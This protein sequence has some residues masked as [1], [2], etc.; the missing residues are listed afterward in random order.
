MSHY[1]KII[2]GTICLL[3]VNFAMA[4]E[5][6]LSLFP[7][8]HY[9]QNVS[10]WIKS[11]DADYDQLLLSDEMQQQRLAIFNEHLFGNDSPWSSEYVTRVMENS[12][13]RDIEYME[14]SLL[15]YFNNK[16]KSE[17]EIGY[18]EN[19]RPYSQKWIHDIAA[20][21]NA[22]QFKHVKYIAD[23]RA[24]AVQNLE[25]RALPTED[26]F[27]NTYQKAGQGYPFDLLQMSAIWAGTPLYILGETQDHAWYLV[28]TPSYI[29]WVKSAGVARA[30]SSFV[31][32][33][34]AAAT[35]MLA[36]ITH[37]KTSISNANG[38][39][40]FYGYVGSVFPVI[41]GADTL[42]LMV[43][44][45]DD[46]NHATIAFA[47][48]SS[49]QAAMMPLAATPHH[50]ADLMK[51]LIGRPYGW[52]GSYFLNDCSQE[53]RSL[54]TP[55]GIWLPRHSSTQVH[56]GKM[57]DMS[58]A[59]KDE[60]INYLMKHGK[61]FLTLIYI[62]GH[63]VLYVGNYQ[64]P[65]QPG[66]MM[67]MTYQDVWGLSPRSHATRH[68]IGGSVLIPMLPQYPEDK[69]LMSLADKKYF[70]MGFLDELPQTHASRH[71]PA[72]VLLRWK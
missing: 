66:S 7:I 3:S 56:E 71:A 63:V 68:V 29:A 31:N 61:K 19:Y 37:T 32:H 49:E 25:A 17:N 35:H 9:D 42:R 60:R 36:A 54:F 69:T 20:N 65:H 52:G 34:R 51:T 2:I 18:G 39:F 1:K 24:I 67:A 33:W 64:N 62:G 72:H 40:L 38:K 58:S 47:S 53:M 27:F 15:Y 41:S 43:P 5:L 30:D 8:E 6:P 14:K 23:N 57:V 10:D 11:T 59:S 22:V 55:F 12:G 13:Y 50:F 21:V 26:V 48:V 45:A 46:S 44:V 4:G 16:G 70:Q 28:I